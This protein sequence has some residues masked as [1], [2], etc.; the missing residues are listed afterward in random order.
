MGLV[1]SYRRSVLIQWGYWFVSQVLVILSFLKI[2]PLWA[3][4][5][6]GS[7]PPFGVSTHVPTL[8]PVAS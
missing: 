7:P 3:S 6:P 5:G 8:L 4:D 1:M 2:Q